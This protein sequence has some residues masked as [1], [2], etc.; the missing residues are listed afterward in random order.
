MAKFCLPIVLALLMSITQAGW[1]FGHE[2]GHAGGCA[3]FGHSNRMVGHDPAAYG[4]DWAANL[5]EIVSYFAHLDDGA[6]GVGDIVE[7]VDHL[8]CG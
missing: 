5:G 6:P 7:N 4:F 8:A 3:A 2:G 1:V